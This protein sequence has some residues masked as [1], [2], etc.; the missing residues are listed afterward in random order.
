MTMAETSPGP[1]DLN[2]TY[3]R[4]G[5]DASIE[6]LPVGNDFW[7]RIMNGALGTFHHEYLATTF[8][9]HCDWPHWEMHPNG[10]EIV[11]L[12]QG[13]A[14]MVLE[15]DGRERLIELVETCS[16]VR[17]PRG[18]WHTGRTREH[19]RMLFITAGEGTEHR[20]IDQT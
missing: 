6:P 20:P 9:Y 17:L 18:T 10:D 2:G 11:C 4:L 3:L 15:I 5:N 13:R 8:A 1:Y 19:C 16:Y 7:Q 12:I 14:T